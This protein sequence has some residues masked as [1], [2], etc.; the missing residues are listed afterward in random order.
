V[1]NPGQ[2]DSISWRVQTTD[3]TGTGASFTLDAANPA[4]NQVAEHFV[5]VTVFKGTVPYNKTVSFKVEL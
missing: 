1:E 5:T 3:V 4:Y 2:Y